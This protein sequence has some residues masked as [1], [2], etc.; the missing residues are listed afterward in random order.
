MAVA[1]GT[2]DGR[3]SRPRCSIRSTSRCGGRATVAAWRF[4]RPRG[5]RAKRR[6]LGRHARCDDA[7][8]RCRALVPWV[9]FGAPL[10]LVFPHAAWA[11]KT[12]R[13]S[14]PYGPAPGAPQGALVPAG[15]SCPIDA[16]AFTLYLAS[17]AS[18]S[19]GAC[20]GFCST[21]SLSTL[22]LVGAVGAYLL[23]GPIV[24]WAHHHVA[25]GF[26]SL[27][28]RLVSPAPGSR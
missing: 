24:H 26:E 8:M 7:A 17:V 3:S 6:N 21:S 4:T 25:R 14:S 27:G 22:L 12:R 11:D 13:A 1:L 10:A 23:G 9:F 5:T 15:E 20:D 28:L 18:Q 2:D 16:G 19:S